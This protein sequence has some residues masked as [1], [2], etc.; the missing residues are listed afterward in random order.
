ML[1]NLKYKPYGSRA[2]LVEWPAKIN[3]NIL[4]DVL[5]LKENIEK[6]NIKEIVQITSS[7]NSLLVF[8]DYELKFISD[9]IS[10][11][12]KIYAAEN[13]TSLKKVNVW[14]IPVCYDTCFGLD[15]EALSI[16][17]NMTIDEI[18]SRH[19]KVVYTVYFIGFL[20]GFLY[21]GGLDSSLITPRKSNPRLHVKKGAVAIGG[22][23]TGVYPNES[24]GG[25][26]IIGNSPI[27]FFDVTKKKPC[28]AEPGDCIKFFPISLKEFQNIKTLVDAGVYQ[29][30]KEEADD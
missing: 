12:D 7:Y 25:W 22:N 13:R 1:F 2:I 14:R 18:I 16:D 10:V 29:I 17:K 11:I 15:L 19:S 30:E 5:I 24:P 26:N 28:F 21:L 4:R 9:E 27:N 3:E 6:S 8:Y 20:P 23:Q